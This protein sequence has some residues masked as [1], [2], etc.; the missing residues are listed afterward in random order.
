[1]YKI[2][3]SLLISLISISTYSQSKECSNFKVGNFRYSH[4]DYSKYKVI[5]TE[6]LQIETDTITGLEIKGTIKWISD[7]EYELIYSEISDSRFNAIIG[8][9]V[10]AY[11]T[12]I[13]ENK[14]MCKSECMGIKLEME[15]IKI[16]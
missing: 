11:I 2:C 14:I 1:M 12:N 6:N 15:M 10:T 8:Q 16:D 13:E 9:K 3:F 7:C 5:R 4:P